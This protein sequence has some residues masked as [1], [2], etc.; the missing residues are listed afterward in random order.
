MK[1]YIKTVII[2]LAGAILL[3]ACSKTAD[4]ANETT[5]ITYEDGDEMSLSIIDFKSSDCFR[6]AKWGMTAS[7]LKS[8][9]YNQSNFADLDDETICNSYIYGEITVSASYHL[10]DGALRRI[11]LILDTPDDYTEEDIVQLY[12]TISAEISETNGSSNEHMK[13]KEDDY[14]E[15]LDDETNQKLTDGSPEKE[16]IKTWTNDT[17]KIELFQSYYSESESF[18]GNVIPAHQSISVAYSDINLS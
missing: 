8:S 18:S 2:I 12:N 4:T 5:V 7:D 9:E 10:R 3:S 16:Y 15:G 14:I 11:S 13:L 17:T 1:H 6:N